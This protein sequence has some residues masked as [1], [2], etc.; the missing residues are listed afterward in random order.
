[1]NA[2]LAFLFNAAHLLAAVMCHRNASS[3]HKH[4]ARALSVLVHA[5]VTA[6]VAAS[7]SAAPPAPATRSPVG[8]S[9]SAARDLSV[10]V[11]DEAGA[12]SRTLEIARAEAGTIW[13]TVGLHLTWTSPPVP[14]GVADGVTVIVRRAWSAPGPDAVDPCVCSNPELGHIVF[15]A[16]GRA[17]NL[18]EVS[19]QALTS[20]VMRG[21]Y[22]NRPISELPDLARNPLLGRGLGRV[23]AHEIGHWLMGRG[24]T[25]KSLMKAVFNAR[26]VLE[27]TA[28]PL[29][30]AWTAAGSALRLLLSSRRELVASRPLKQDVTP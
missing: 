6:S 21:S 27:W 24:H 15:R 23:V 16:D 25:Q 20:L 1:M 17:G 8:A 13:A 19:Y 10:Y 12:P 11:I 22:M 7:A 14:L 5:A 26:D 18:I 4:R 28:P 9:P 2:T 29:P 3:A 30:A